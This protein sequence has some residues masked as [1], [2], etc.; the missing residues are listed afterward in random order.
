MGWLS[1][2]SVILGLSLSP[3]LLPGPLVRRLG[4]E[5]VVVGVNATPIG[6]VSRLESIVGAD[7]IAPDLA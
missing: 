3:F 1:V 2:T 5:R 6:V 7:G 4:L